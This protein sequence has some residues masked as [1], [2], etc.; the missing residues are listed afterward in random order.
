MGI[1]PPAGLSADSPLERD[2]RAALATLGQRLH[3][4]LDGAAVE[5]TPAEH[6]DLQGH[7]RIDTTPPLNRASMAPQGWLRPYSHPSGRGTGPERP[8]AG[9]AHWGRAAAARRITLLA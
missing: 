3:R 7:P 4:A 8:N 5:Q 9:R 2:A 1:H 6:I